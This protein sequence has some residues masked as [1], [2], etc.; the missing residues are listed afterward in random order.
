MLLRPR[1]RGE[2]SG[3]LVGAAPDPRESGLGW[4]WLGNVA[5]IAERLDLQTHVIADSDARST[6]MCD[7]CQSSSGSQNDAKFDLKTPS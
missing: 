3:N 7:Y 1:G 4:M 2:L 6:L 5:D